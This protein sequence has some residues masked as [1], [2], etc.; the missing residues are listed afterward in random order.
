[1]PRINAVRRTL[2]VSAMIALSSIAC[3]SID[4]PIRGLGA[5]EIISGNDQD[6]VIGQ[7]SAVQ[8]IVRAVSQDATGAAGVTVNWT[9]AMGGGSLSAPSSVTDGAGAAAVNYTPGNTAETVFIRARAEDLSVTFTL[10]VITP[11][12]EDGS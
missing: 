9:I 3:T 10:N 8:L 5:L 2:W 4:E 12:V 1:M 6:L 11:P 7:T